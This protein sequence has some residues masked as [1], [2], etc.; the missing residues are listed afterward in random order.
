MF[1]TL[2]ENLEYVI[3][4]NHSMVLAG[5]GTQNWIL[6]G[7]FFR[8]VFELPFAMFLGSHFDDFGLPLGPQWEPLLGPKLDFLGSHFLNS[9]LGPIRQRFWEGPAAEAEPV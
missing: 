2:A 4:E 3:F 6:F 8:H 7:S 1:E 9:F 5:P